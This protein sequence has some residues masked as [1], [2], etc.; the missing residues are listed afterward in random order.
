MAHTVFYNDV[1]IFMSVIFL[2]AMLRYAS[3]L[4]FDE[5]HHL[6]DIVIPATADCVGVEVLRLLID[7][8][9]VGHDHAAW[10]IVCVDLHGFEEA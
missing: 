6:W 4:C 5:I 7:Q 3:R 9:E 1:I 2:F 8:V 10:A